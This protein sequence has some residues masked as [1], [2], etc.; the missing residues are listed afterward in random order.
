MDGGRSSFAAASRKTSSTSR[1]MHEGRRACGSKPARQAAASQ[2]FARHLRPAL[3]EMTRCRRIIRRHFE[4]AEPRHEANLDFFSVLLEI[5]DDLHAVN[6]VTAGK[7]RA[8]A[9]P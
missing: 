4:R 1:A 8:I 6:K 7:A 3:H 5:L 9:H 2:P